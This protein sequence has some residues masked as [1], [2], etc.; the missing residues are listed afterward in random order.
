MRDPFNPAR[1]GMPMTIL[2]SSM[3]Y[4]LRGGGSTS[5]RPQRRTLRFER[6]FGIKIRIRLVRIWQR[7]DC[8]NGV[9]LPGTYKQTYGEIVNIEPNAPEAHKNP[10]SGHRSYAF[11]TIIPLF[12]RSSIPYGWHNL[13]GQ[14]NKCKFKE[15]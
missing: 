3:A 12:Q 8:H 6:F 5:R 14:Q 7:H 11:L 4:S 13:K 1:A 10:R 15:L 2:W 9:V